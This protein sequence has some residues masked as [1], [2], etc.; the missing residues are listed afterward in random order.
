MHLDAIRPA[1][2][3]FGVLGRGGTLQLHLPYSEF[4]LHCIV[5]SQALSF[6]SEIRNVPGMVGR[7]FG[8]PQI[9]GGAP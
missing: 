9:R 2:Y 8:L 3:I 7:R 1:D 4:P 5:D 6:F